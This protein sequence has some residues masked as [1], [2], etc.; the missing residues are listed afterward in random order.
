MRYDTNYESSGSFIGMAVLLLILIIIY[1][2]GRAYYNNL[3]GLY[4][5]KRIIWATILGCSFE[6]S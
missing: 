1:T 6:K 2:V 4:M 5:A 3:A